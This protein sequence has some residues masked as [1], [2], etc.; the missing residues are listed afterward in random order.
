MRFSVRSLGGKLIIVAA[1]T[2]LLCM[3][4]FSAISWEVLKYV[5]EREARSEAPAHLSLVKHSFYTQNTL[6]TKNLATVTQNPTVASL[7]TQPPSLSRQQ[8]LQ[9]LLAPVALQNQGIV[10]LSLL[11]KNNRLSGQLMKPGYT[12]NLS[13]PTLKALLKQTFLGKTAVS[14]RS[15]AVTGGSPPHSSTSWVLTTALPVEERGGALGGAIVGA[16]IVSQ[17]IDTDFVSNLAQAPDTGIILCLS[18]Q[19]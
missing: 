4:L 11:S 19:I 16:L 7:V 10:S 6:L 18:D 1:L 5:S 17:A 9:S 2:L 12:E 3:L 15:L 13:S 8:E 14:L